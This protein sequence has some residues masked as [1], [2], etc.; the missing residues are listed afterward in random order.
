MLLWTE[1][2]IMTT[3]SIYK[4]GIESHIVIHGSNDQLTEADHWMGTWFSFAYFLIVR[5]MYST[6]GLLVFLRIVTISRSVS[7]KQQVLIDNDI[8]PKHK[9]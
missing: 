6:C 5:M 2:I 9:Q 8:H 3:H 7:L 1:L 4:D